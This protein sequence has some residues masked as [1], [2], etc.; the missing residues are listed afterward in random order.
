MASHLQQLQGLSLGFN[1]ARYHFLYAFSF[2]TSTTYALSDNDS[3]ISQPLLN[4]S[5][6]DERRVLSQLSDL[7]Q[8]SY[9]NSNPTIPNLYKDTYPPKQLQSRAVDE[10]LL[11]EEKL[12]GV[13]LQKL[14]G[15]VSEMERILEAMIADGF[16][17]DCSTFSYVI[18]GLG[19]A[20]RIDDAVEIFDHMKDKGCIPDTRVYNAMISNFVSI[21][22]LMEEALQKGFFPSRFICSKLNNKLLAS[23][24]VEKAYKLLLK[25]KAARRDENAQKYWRANGWHF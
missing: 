9:S 25:I 17:P 10:F 18:E 16:T 11:P 15:R 6:V 22:L 14:S 19:R 4:Q 24:E 21:V 13:F 20:G 5:N 8:F 3:S 1:R 7:F 2:S 23:N 12:R